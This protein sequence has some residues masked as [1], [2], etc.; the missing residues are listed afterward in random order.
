VTLDAAYAGRLRQ[1]IERPAARGPSTLGEI[2]SSEW[3]A[4][5]LDTVETMLNPIGDATAALEQKIAGQTGKSLFDLETETGVTLG[6]RRDI[7]GRVAQLQQLIDRLPED[8]RKPLEA[9]RDVVGNARRKAREI[10]QRAEEVSSS[11]YGLSGYATAF[12]AGISRQMVSPVNIAL[13][14]LGG[15]LKGSIPRML[16]RE[17]AFGAAGQAVQEPFIAAGRE[18]LGLQ[19]TSIENIAQAAIGQALFAGVFRAGA[20]GFRAFREAEA[21]RAQGLTPETAPLAAQ[22]E[23]D[24]DQLSPTAS[25]LEAGGFRSPF[26]RS[27]PVDGAGRLV[28]D[29]A[30]FRSP[31][32]PLLEAGAARPPA[33]GGRE[34]PA[35]LTARDPYSPTAPLLEAKAQSVTFT[36][37]TLAGPV[38]DVATRLAPED[39]EAVALLA[40]RNAAL[41]AQAEAL[42]DVPVARAA[43]DA[44]QQAETVIIPNAERRAQF[45]DLAA[46]HDE[47]PQILSV[48]TPDGKVLYAQRNGSFPNGRVALMW[49]EDVRLAD[50]IGSNE[51]KPFQRAASAGF[52]SSNPGSKIAVAAV[53]DDVVAAW[54]AA[55]MDEASGIASLISLQADAVEQA[56][57]ALE[58]GRPVPQPAAFTVRPEVNFDPVR[59]RAERVLRARPDLDAALQS[60]AKA[61]DA[62]AVPDGPFA[63]AFFADDAKT[64]P[65]P[66]DLA[67]DR[68]TRA[69]ERALSAE[70]SGAP[71]WSLDG[72]AKLAERIDRPVSD[73]GLPRSA[74]LEPPNPGTARVRTRIKGEAPARAQAAE[75]A[76]DGLPRVALLEP[77]KLDMR[78]QRIINTVERELGELGDVRVELD[79]PDGRRITSAREMLARIADDEQALAALDGCIVNGDQS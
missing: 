12:A 36:E 60:V 74:L 5:G 43:T 65:L 24:L 6:P 58:A 2:W 18:Q 1:L 48:T 68:I 54:R 37:P 56:A 78:S 4:S 75:A 53:P 64:V 9:D 70:I 8:Q 3:A 33:G 47:V 14:P 55:A 7:G 34:A 23:Q 52:G 41:D 10:E 77:R 13:M 76:S 61:L 62:G 17:A 79:G 42:R 30:D 39:F 32:A 25:L 63:R 11:T 67:I 45:V 21:M 19:S 27:A 51:V 22:L 73:R 26:E 40:E 31:V 20:A 28:M 16:A 50:P 46:R 57:R 66:R 69:G 15:P 59:S 44:A 49:T 29:A 35:M 71:A 72:I 38:R